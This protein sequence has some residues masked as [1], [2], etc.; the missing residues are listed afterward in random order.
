MRKSLYILA[1]LAA[2]LALV[3]GACTGQS[4]VVTPAPTGDPAA[5][6]TASR[7][8]AQATPSR[9]SPA[10]TATAVSGVDASSPGCTVQSPF[11]TAGPT[12]QSMF[13]APG[14][15][16]WTL[17]PADAQTTLTEYSDFQ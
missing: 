11:P 13:P 16:D 15:D 2:L 4:Q 7:A 17:G 12:E 14:E 1:G 8:V 3:L 5:K 6:P 10:G 9:T